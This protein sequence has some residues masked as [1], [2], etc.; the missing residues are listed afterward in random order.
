MTYSIK[1][2][3]VKLCIIHSNTSCIHMWK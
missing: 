1:L 3:V 2:A